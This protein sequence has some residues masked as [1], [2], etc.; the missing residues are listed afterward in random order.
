MNEKQGGQV[1]IL[2]CL[3]AWG[4]KPSSGI[5]FNMRKVFLVAISV[6]QWNGCWTRGEFAGEWIHVYVWLSPFAVLSDNCNYHSIVNQLYPN[7]NKKLKKKPM[8]WLYSEL[9]LRRHVQ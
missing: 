2:Y 6:Q 8:E 1:F 7:T 3:R 4:L 9:F 5:Q